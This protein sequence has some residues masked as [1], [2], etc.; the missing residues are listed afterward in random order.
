MD[1]EASDILKEFITEQH[2]DYKLTLA[3]L[4]QRNW[5]E[6]EIQT[7]KNNFIAGLFSTDPNFPLNVWCKLVAQ[8]VVTL[9]LLLHSRI[10][11]KLSSHAQV[12]VNLNYE[13]TPM[14]PPVIKVLLH[15]RP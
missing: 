6:R 10:N 2:V 14:A 8:Y 7:L 12:F 11:P 5:D 15:E 9:N 1:N 13:R 3:G 4:H